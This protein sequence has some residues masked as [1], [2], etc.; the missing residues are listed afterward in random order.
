MKNKIKKEIQQLLTKLRNSIPESARAVLDRLERLFVDV[1]REVSALSSNLETAN[2]S[3]NHIKAE[4]DELSHALDSKK[5]ELQIVKNELQRCRSRERDQSILIDSIAASSQAI[6]N[7]LLM[8][9]YEIG[10]ETPSPF[11]M[12]E[13]FTRIAQRNPLMKIIGELLAVRAVLD[14]DDYDDAELWRNGLSIVDEEL[15]VCAY[16]ELTGDLDIVVS[17]LTLDELRLAIRN[18]GIELEIP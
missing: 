15:K 10:T 2:R 9:E 4:R 1:R 3:K 5:R 17:V 14:S 6:V 16:A 13:G 8:C 12:T 7:N 11:R 18:E